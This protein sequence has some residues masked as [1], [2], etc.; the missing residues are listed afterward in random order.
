VESSPPFRI[1]KVCN[2]VI[3]LFSMTDV[4]T[5]C[6][7]FATCTGDTLASELGILSESPPRLVTAPWRTVPPGTNGGMSVLGTAASALGGAFIGFVMGLGLMAEGAMCLVGGGGLEGVLRLTVLG[8]IAG[9]AGSYVSVWSPSTGFQ[10]RLS[11][12]TTRGID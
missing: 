10:A 4:S 3:S 7:H 1:S 11:R 8:S 9:T 12:Y 6:S 5:P 2:A